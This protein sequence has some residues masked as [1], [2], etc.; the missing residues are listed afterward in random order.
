MLEGKENSATSFEVTTYPLVREPE[1]NTHKLQSSLL[2][3]FSESLRG[4][5]TSFTA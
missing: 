1:V 5:H 3:C 4:P 2:R